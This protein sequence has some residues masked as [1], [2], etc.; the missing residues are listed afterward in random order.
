MQSSGDMVSG[1]KTFSKEAFALAADL[2][3]SN[4]PTAICVMQH[5]KRTKMTWRGAI[6]DTADEFYVRYLQRLPLGMSYVQQVREISQLLRRPPLDKGCELIIDET[7]VG[8]PVGD[9][10]TLLKVNPIRVVITGGENQ[11]TRAS[12]RWHVPKGLLISA[13][14]ARLHTQELKIAPDLAE[15]SALREELRD[16][17]RHISAAG[18]YSYDARVGKHDDLVLA[19]A[20]ALWNFIG[21]PKA[22]SAVVGRYS[23]NGNV[24]FE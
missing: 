21:R 19:V 8:R 16:F 13:L 18:R 4:D 14:D 3:Q 10:F 5:I 2:G 15:A 20:L 24:H 12:S 22:P 9:L 7:G 6:V 23:L 11:S 1:V 17:R